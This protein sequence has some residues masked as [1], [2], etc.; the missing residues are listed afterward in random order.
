MNGCPNNFFEKE[1]SIPFVVCF[2]A[3][4]G[5]QI[6]VMH[7]QKK[8]GPKFFIP[9]DLRRD[10]N[11]YNYFYKFKKRPTS[12]NDPEVASYQAEEHIECAICM[13]KIIWEIDQEGNL[14]N[15]EKQIEMTEIASRNQE[16]PE[17]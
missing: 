14:I 8:L 15:D 5:G 12:Q 4:V 2:V 3:F 11:A 10:P 6:M 1:A 9:Y 17:F 16:L 13:N 7:Y